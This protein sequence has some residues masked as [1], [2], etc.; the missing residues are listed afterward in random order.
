MAGDQWSPIR[1]VRS[2][3]AQRDV[4]VMGKILKFPSCS[5]DRNISFVGGDVPDA[6]VLKFFTI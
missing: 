4:F 2:R 6:P 5:N 3:I 1:I